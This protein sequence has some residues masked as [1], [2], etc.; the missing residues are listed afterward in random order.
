MTIVGESVLSSV[1]DLF[2]KNKFDKDFE[3]NNKPKSRKKQQYQN[4]IFN[5]FSM[6]FTFLTPSFLTTI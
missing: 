6:L 3:T 4:F 2:S 1:A 5:F